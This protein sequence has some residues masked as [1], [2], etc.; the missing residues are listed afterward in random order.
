LYEANFNKQD[1]LE[2]VTRAK[3]ATKSNWKFLWTKKGDVKDL[4][5]L[6]NDHMKSSMQRTSI[7]EVWFD[8][9]GVVEK[10]KLD[11][12][13]GFFGTKNSSFFVELHDGANISIPLK[14][15]DSVEIEYQSV[16]G[17]VGTQ[18]Y[19]ITILAKGLKVRANFI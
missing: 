2:L 18:I 3:Y 7:V 12:K 9:V 4:T 10:G 8:N 11:A 16:A 14:S 13:G 5:T 1:E 17:D 19:K 6:I 15:I